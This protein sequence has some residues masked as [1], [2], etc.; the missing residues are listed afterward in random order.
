MGFSQKILLTDESVPTKFHCQEDRKRRIFDAGPYVEVFLKR[1]R[2]NLVTESLRTQSSTE[3]HTE[4][5]QNDIEPK[6]SPK[7]QDKET[8]TDP[9]TNVENSVQEK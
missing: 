8:I 1:Q 7:T 9:I 4:S 6:E 3:T 2:V 5:L